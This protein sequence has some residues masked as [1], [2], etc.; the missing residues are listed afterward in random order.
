MVSFITRTLSMVNS[1]TF[2]YLNS[3]SFPSAVLVV[4]PQ[5]SKQ[6]QQHRVQE[7]KRRPNN[8]LSN[9]F[10]I[11]VSS[12][13]FVPRCK[14]W[15]GQCDLELEAEVLEFMKTSSNP[16]KFPSKS[17]LI[18]AGR[19]DLVRAIVK[20]GGWM[21]IGWD[22][23]YHVEI[24]GDGGITGT[25]GEVGLAGH[26]ENGALSEE[27]R[28]KLDGTEDSL[29][30]GDSSPAASSSGSSPET[31]TEDSGIHGILNRLERQRNSIL[32]LD[33]GKDGGSNHATNSSLDGHNASRLDNADGDYVDQSGQLISV[34]AEKSHFNDSKTSYQRSFSSFNGLSSSLKPDTWRSWSL[35]RAGPLDITFQA[36]EIDLNKSRKGSVDASV[37]E[38]IATAENDEEPAVKSTE[39][40]SLSKIPSHQDIRRRLQD[41]ELELSS[42]LHL[43]RSNGTDLSQKDD[44]Q[45][46]DDLGNLS[47]VWEFQ[48][49]EVMNAHDKLRALRAKL[50][51]LEGKM[52]LSV[53]DARKL[54]NEKE[55]KIDDARRALKL[56]RSIYVI[57]PNPASEVLLTGSFDGWTTQV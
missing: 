25:N 47:D 7:L 44:E 53:R 57:W 49:T 51:V 52:T 42:A 34:S 50:A 38:K 9:Q 32:G 37:N 40:T 21:S 48:E 22:W 33:L 1:Q 26:H 56:L 4:S 16:E 11:H 29:F 6:Q 18:E 43:L 27:S 55:K 35:R 41:L 2:V 23:D 28:T 30:L 10:V 54:V 45:L 20:S 46:A 15:E 13:Y 3:L 5:C 39:L 36:A 31:D 17:D 12:D 19:M 24:A 8:Q 14:R